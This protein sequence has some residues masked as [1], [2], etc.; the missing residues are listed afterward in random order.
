[1][2]ILIDGDASI[3]VNYI[4]R[5]EKIVVSPDL[6]EPKFR[7]VLD[8]SELA[9]KRDIE[10]NKYSPVDKLVKKVPSG[11]LDLYVGVRDKWGNTTEKRMPVWVIPG[12]V[13]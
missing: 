8:G 7:A 3:K 13:M 4:D 10:E 9:L 2:P 11:R 12:P 5:D 6:A 1:M